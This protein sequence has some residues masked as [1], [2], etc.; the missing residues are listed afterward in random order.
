MTRKS[1]YQNNPET[2]LIPNSL[3]KAGIYTRL[4]V[5]DGDD[6]S[7]SITNQI[8][9]VMNYIN[10]CEDLEYVK[11]YTDD[12]YTGQNFDRPGFCQMIQDAKA[13]LINCIIVKDISRLGRNYPY[14]NSY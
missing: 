11:T 3:T 13:G 1:R 7:E 2:H 4:S 6:L 9:I 14:F 8:K 5:S 10:H 12:G